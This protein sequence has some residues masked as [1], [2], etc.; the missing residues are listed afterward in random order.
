MHLRGLNPS[1]F[2]SLLSGDASAR[3]PEGTVGSKWRPSIPYPSAR[4]N[5]TSRRF[6]AA[7]RIDSNFNK[8]QTPRSLGCEWKKVRLIETAA[9][10]TTRRIH[11]KWNHD[12]GGLVGTLSGA[13]TEGTDTTYID[14]FKDLSLVNHRLYRQGRVPMVRFGFTGP[15]ATTITNAAVAA[16]TLPNT[17]QVRKA[18]QLALKEY[19]RATKEERRRTGQARW[20]DF[21]VWLEDGQRSGTTLV[22]AGITVG[23]AEW[24]YSEIAD[25]VDGSERRFKFLGNTDGNAWGMISQYDNMADTDN[26]SPDNPGASTPYSTLHPDVQDNNQDNLL[27]EGD[28][29]PYNPENLQVQEQLHVIGVGSGK[30]D[31]MVSEWFPAPCGLLRIMAACTSSGAIV[32]DELGGFFVEVAAGD[33]KGVHATPMGLKL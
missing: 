17:W 3:P 12:S 28:A 8:V 26:D 31:K 25:A 4:E 10:A 21:K 6:S 5:V 23:T 16:F 9:G 14:L 32:D 27:D 13:E 30:T 1:G 29:P 18:H 11:Y 2:F 15:F 19:L 22:P 33:Y 20:H 24:A 7:D